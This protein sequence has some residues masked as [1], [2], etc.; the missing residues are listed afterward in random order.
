MNRSLERA[1]LHTVALC[2]TASPVLVLA[3]GTK[4]ATVRLKHRRRWDRK[5]EEA[6]Q[7]VKVP[8][9]A[10]ASEPRAGALVSVGRGK[11]VQPW[12]PEAVRMV[13]WFKSPSA[14][15]D[16]S[17]RERLSKMRASGLVGR[18]K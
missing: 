3:R 11:F 13:E 14:K 7:V 15:S 2:D 4:Y 18:A 5:W 9:F 1:W 16:R 6:G 17:T 12:S 10:L 8:L